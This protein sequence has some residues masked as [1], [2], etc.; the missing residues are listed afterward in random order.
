MTSTY[1]TC[2]CGC[3]ESVHFTFGE[4]ICVHAY[5]II[6]PC[7]CIGFEEVPEEQISE[8]EKEKAHL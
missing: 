2:K 8:P 5:D 1:P 7:Y 4:R 3:T 6:N